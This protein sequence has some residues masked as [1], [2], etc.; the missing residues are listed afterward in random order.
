[1][2]ETP[3]LPPGGVFVIGG[4]LA[5]IA[6]EPLFSCACLLLLVCVGLENTVRSHLQQPHA[7]RLL[8]DLVN[9]CAEPEPRCRCCADAL[10]ILNRDSMLPKLPAWSPLSHSE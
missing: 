3:I 6:C 2:K 7:R 5:L 9:C 1:M 4:C 10:F 8:A